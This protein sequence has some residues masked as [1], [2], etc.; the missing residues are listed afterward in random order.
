MFREISNQLLCLPILLREEYDEESRRQN[1]IRSFCHSRD[2][3]VYHVREVGAIL[4]VREEKVLCKLLCRQRLCPDLFDPICS[5]L[6]VTYTQCP[7]KKYARF[8]SKLIRNECIRDVEHAI[9][10]AKKY[11]SLL[12]HYNIRGYDESSF[13][14]ELSQHATFDYN[15]IRYWLY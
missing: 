8:V 6:S 11:D 12:P 14:L 7:Q 3:V 10:V 9:V 2:M 1:H 5:Y 15:M 4:Q 13:Y